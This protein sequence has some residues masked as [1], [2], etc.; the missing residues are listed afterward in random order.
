MPIV[1]ADRVLETSTT[2][3]TG[4][5]TLAGAATGYQAFATGVGVG[6][7]TYY[8]IFDP[9][10]NTWEVG[11]GTL[12]TGTTLSR[13]TVYANSSDTTAL[14]SFAANSK[15]VFCTSPAS[16]YV[17]Q[18]DIGTAPNQ[19]PLNQYLGNL[20]YQDAG[21]IA[22]NVGIGGNL[23]VNGTIINPAFTALINSIYPQLEVYAAFVNMQDCTYV[24]TTTIPGGVAVY[25][26]N[27]GNNTGWTFV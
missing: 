4:T 24:G 5:L 18:S 2:S 19:I 23:T 21:T 13:T 16:K 3:G 1:V 8:T 10:D 7:Q 12:L 25:S 27:N 9:T 26:T 22:G 15:N 6:N 17:D 11:I 20:A 14:I